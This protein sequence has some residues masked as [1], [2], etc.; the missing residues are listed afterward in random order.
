MTYS[1][2]RSNRL[3]PSRQRGFTLIELMIAVLIA[4][5]LIGGLLTLVQ[6][7]KRTS[8]NQ[9]GLSQLQDSE[10]M[11]M[12]L[13]GD[14]IQSTGYFTN[15]LSNTA[16]SSFPVTGAFTFNGQALVGTGTYG[17]PG[18]TITVRY[19]TSG[20][21]NIINCT[22]NTS[23]VGAATFVNKFSIDANGNLQCQLTVNG[24]VSPAVPL[25]GGLQNLQIY[26]GVQTN[27][28]VNTN[29]VDAYLDATDV[30]KGNYWSAV[31]SVKIT[32]TFVNPL[33]G[34]TATTPATIAFTRIIAVMSNTGVST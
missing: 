32:L 20:A 29:S 27:T 21:D 4:L 10:R 6:S 2:P 13:I 16:T 28:S 15:P 5:F 18:H 22:G 1:T 33:A 19:M 14:V 34:Q 25:I 12:T 24:T 23:S 17:T 31:K 30:A 8:Q 7:M 11:A 3:V 26:Y 9:S